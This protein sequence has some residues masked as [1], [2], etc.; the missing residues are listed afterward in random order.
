MAEPLRLGAHQAAEGSDREGS[1]KARRGQGDR[2][3]GGEHP[4]A[5]ELKSPHARREASLRGGDAEW[6]QGAEEG[7]RTEGHRTAGAPEAERRGVDQRSQT[8]AKSVAPLVQE[9]GPKQAIP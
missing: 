5:P 7:P 3:L 1:F 6:E 4:L 9:P 2:P 8:H